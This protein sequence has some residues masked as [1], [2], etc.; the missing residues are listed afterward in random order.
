VRSFLIGAFGLAEVGGGDGDGCDGCGFGAEDAGAEGYGLPLVLGEEGD[1]F[2]GPAA[3]RAYG[4]GV[5][6]G[7]THVRESGPFGRLRAGWRAPGFVTLQCVGE[8][9]GLLGFA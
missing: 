4:Y 8:G 3:F 2:G 7:R 6:D 9:G 1:L 5:G